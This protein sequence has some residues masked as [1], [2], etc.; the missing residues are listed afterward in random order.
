MEQWCGSV[1]DANPID[2]QSPPPSQQ[3]H[4]HVCESPTYAVISDSAQ[5]TTRTPAITNTSRATLP[6]FFLSVR[7]S[8]CQKLQMTA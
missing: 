5:L 1:S 2:V 6:S 7:V 8:G 3:T 4:R